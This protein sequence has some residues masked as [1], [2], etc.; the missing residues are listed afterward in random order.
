LIRIGPFELEAPI[1]RGGMGEVWKGL[2]TER[3]LPV[4]VK[5]ITQERAQKPHYLSAFRN[6][7]RTAAGL[8]HPSIV[9][10]LD[11]GQVP[12]EAAKASENRFTAGSPFLVME[13]LDAGSLKRRIGKM[14][15]FELSETLLA[16]LDALA[17]A[18]ARG[19]IHRDLKPANVLLRHG[20]EVKLTDFGLAHALELEAVP[21][22]PWQ[23]EGVGTPGY[24]SPEQ[25]QRRWRD[26]GPW[27][28]LYAFGCLA[29]EMVSGNL[30]F[31]RHAEPETLRGHLSRPVPKLEPIFPVPSG[32]ESWI[33]QLLEKDPGDRYRRAADAAAALM[34]LGPG[35][36]DQVAQRAD[37][38]TE[39][40]LLAHAEPHSLPTLGS[41][42]DLA[43]RV[44]VAENTEVQPALARKQTIAR[45][46]M[47]ASWRPPTQAPV[48]MRLVGA[49]LGLY[50]LRA[51]RLVDREIERDALWAQLQKTEER[52]RAHVAILEGPS[53][54]GKSRL[55]EWLCERA[56][57]VGAATPLKAVHG[58]NVGT[59]DGLGP[60]LQRHL[61]AVGLSRAELKERLETLLRAQR[62]ERRDEAM[63]LTEMISPR[64]RE[65]E[66]TGVQIVR[67]HNLREKHVL[68]A[69]FLE[70]LARERPVI[71]WLDDAQF[72][73]DALRF[74]K[75]LMELQ[76]DAPA[77]VLVLI[78]VREEAIAERESEAEILRDLS[79]LLETTKIAVHALDPKYRAVLV[80]E[81]LGLEGELASRVEERTA[82]N[83]LF[84][85][86]LVGDWVERGLLEPGPQGFRLKSGAHVELPDDIHQVW[87]ARVDRLLSER[88]DED[89]QALEIAA[90]LGQDVD[91]DEWRD[92]ALRAGIQASTALVEALIVQRLASAGERGPEAGWSFVHGMLRESL[93]RKAREAG[94]WK[95]YHHACAQM[96]VSRLHPV[97]A[98]RLGRHLLEAGRAAEA[99]DPL[100]RGALEK[101]DEGD[102]RLAEIL[103]GDRERAMKEIDLSPK[104]PRWGEGWVHR[105]RLAGLRGD[106]QAGEYW[107]RLAASDAR[108]H[109]WLGVAGMAHREL[110][111][112]ARLKGDHQHASLELELAQ[113]FA[114]RVNDRRL[115]AECKR[116]VAYLHLGRGRLDFAFD[117][118]EL[119]RDDYVAIDDTIGTARAY[120]GLG[121]IAREAGRLE[122]ASGY[123]ETARENFER[124][125]SRKGVS[126]CLNALGEIARLSG[127]LERAEQHY[128]D[129]LEIRRTLG[130]ADAIVCEL[131]LSLVRIERGRYPEARRSL[132][133]CLKTIERRG[134]KKMMGSVHVCLLP[135]LVALAEGALFDRHL[136]QAASLLGET[137]FVD[138]DN[139]RMSELAGDLAVKANDSE[140]AREAYVIARHQW[141]ALGRIEEERSVEAKLAALG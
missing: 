30:P 15:F 108:R 141:K 99:I 71:A 5:V 109:R 3:N 8:D 75:T 22:E 28:D 119:A 74:A 91:G 67:F 12:N 131:N 35:P 58:K 60:M 129:A 73:L 134:N 13:Y 17:H 31:G 136:R 72:G 33:R 43:T 88:P 11:Y 44:D 23:I 128:R 18:H 54:C 2:H 100:T 86:Q 112:L 105:G 64:D 115:L 120:I 50:G 114:T 38:A 36:E 93:E 57:E 92:V 78:T 116:D 10:V 97:S 61:R 140:R 62:I 96:L 40:G 42:L 123:V 127:D 59:T 103:L 9:M 45:P 53:G 84:A 122:D 121:E 7:V 82:G 16:L 89:R 132:E 65:D 66:T 76:A 110:G 26:F 46:R 137:G 95:A 117:Y 104:D 70:R 19:M 81:L 79:A 14:R 77:S 125:G 56:H 107:T 102:Y 6:E 98:M 34:D 41:T 80:R 39:A 20:G 138:V 52:K 29:F 133:E 85:V 139:A 51:I 69:R 68:V 47:P 25:I 126:D 48:S 32:F 55:A 49:G 113:A 4:A 21:S 124:C 1:G 37:Q 90:I 111:R 118:F 24:M 130:A 135:C 63:A 106:P 83:P 27:T 87:S 101:L 94:R